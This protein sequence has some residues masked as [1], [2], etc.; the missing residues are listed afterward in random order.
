MRTM[1]AAAVTVVGVLGA[2]AWAA[3]P[4]APSM[5][6]PAVPSAKPAMPGAPNAPSAAQRGAYL[7]GILSCAGCHSPW[8]EHGMDEA[9]VYGGNAPHEPGK[10]GNPNITP[11]PVT[12]IGTWT[13]AQ[14]VAAIR[15]GKRPDGTRLSPHMPS[16]TYH[17]LTDADA[18][19]LVAFLRTVKPVVNRVPRVPADPAEVATWPAIPTT[20]GF[21]DP[22]EP[23]GHGAYLAGLLRCEGCHT[24]PADSPVAGRRYAG[25]KEF[26]GRGPSDKKLYAAN[27]T[28]DVDTGIGAWTLEDLAASITELVRPDGSK[29]QGPMTFRAHAWEQVTDDDA[30]AVGAFLKSLPAVKHKVGAPPEPAKG[31]SKAKARKKA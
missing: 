5:G 30:K 16:E 17:G 8:G 31:K 9:K 26:K 10:S 7:A 21:V 18:N 19:A 14:I 22:A 2:A 27:L 20:S 11:D 1:T 13:D 28:P 6:T 25:G 29:I 12:G 3:F 24:P 23:A 4:S 15:D